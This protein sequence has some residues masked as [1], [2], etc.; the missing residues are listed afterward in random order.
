MWSNCVAGTLTLL[1]LPPACLRHHLLDPAA[2]GDDDGEGPVF[3]APGDVA[4]AHQVVDHHADGL[5]LDDPH[6]DDSI[7]GRLVRL[8]SEGY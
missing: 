1:R 7:T 3:I 5:G 2:P 6:S 4:G 8:G